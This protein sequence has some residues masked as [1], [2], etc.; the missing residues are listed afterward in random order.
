MCLQQLESTAAALLTSQH[1]VD[2]STL[3]PDDFLSDTDAFV[4]RMPQ[5]MPVPL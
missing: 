1:C 2:I 3:V 5:V 4:Q